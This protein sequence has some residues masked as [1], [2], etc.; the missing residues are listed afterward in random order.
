MHY[1]F[2]KT[3]YG[4]LKHNSLYLGLVLASGGWQSLIAYIFKSVLFHLTFVTES[5]CFCKWQSIPPFF[6]S[7]ELYFVLLVT[8]ALKTLLSISQN[9]ISPIRLYK[10]LGNH[11][12]RNI[13]NVSISLSSFPYW[14]RDGSIQGKK[15]GKR[16]GSIHQIFLF[17]LSSAFL[18]A[19]LITSTFNQICSYV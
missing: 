9:G 13:I 7:E 1:V 15:R 17:P 10:Q 5:W 3:N 18:K 16:D 11:L 14:W 12:N 19:Y 8:L 4:G 6:N 2:G